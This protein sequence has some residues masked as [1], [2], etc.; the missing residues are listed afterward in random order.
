M[1][2][3]YYVI[4][5]RTGDSAL[6]GQRLKKAQMKAQLG[7]VRFFSQTSLPVQGNLT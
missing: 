6:C 4:G 2:H 1:A 5:A 7:Q 3:N